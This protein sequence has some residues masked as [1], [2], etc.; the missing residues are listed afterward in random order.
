MEWWGISKEHGWVVLDR[1]IPNNRPGTWANLIFFRCCD[2]TI[3]EEKSVKWNLPNYV[4]SDS[5]LKSLSGLKAINEKKEFDKIKAEY[6]NKKNKLYKDIMRYKYNNYNNITIEEKHKVFL[7]K[8]GIQSKGA[9]KP[10]SPHGRRESICWNCKYPVDNVDDFECLICG[11]IICS[12]C[13]AC[14]CTRKFYK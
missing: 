13:G 8:Y 10:N 1:S 12:I 14:E 2:W 3:Y 9:R 6:N 4:F 7:K 5:Y 11:W